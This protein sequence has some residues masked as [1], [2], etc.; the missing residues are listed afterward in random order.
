MNNWTF[1]PYF[2]PAV[3]RQKFVATGGGADYIINLKDYAGVW[4]TITDGFF[5]GSK[6]RIYRV[7]NN[8]VQ[9]KRTDTVIDY[10]V[11]YAVI[12][13]VYTS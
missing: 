5:N 2:E 12:D 4:E 9:L 8:T 6:V 7:E 3:L 11:D 10:K 13:Y 1:N